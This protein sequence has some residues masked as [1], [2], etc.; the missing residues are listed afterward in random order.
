MMVRMQGEGRL[1]RAGNTACIRAKESDRQPVRTVFKAYTE[2]AHKCRR[3]AKFSLLAV[4]M[5]VTSKGWMRSAAECSY[6]PDKVL[7]HT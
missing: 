6:S 3:L 2:D 1:E 5:C 7:M 4:S